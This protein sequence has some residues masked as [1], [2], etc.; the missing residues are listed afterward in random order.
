MTSGFFHGS[1]SPNP[2]SIPLGSFRIF[3]KIRGDIRSL[4][5]TT[6]VIATSTN[7]TSDIVG[8]FA[9]GVVDTGFIYMLIL[10]PKGV[11]KKS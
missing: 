9:A 7:D 5:C 3:S 4:R 8:K 6:G 11:Q 10:L 1:G 2:L